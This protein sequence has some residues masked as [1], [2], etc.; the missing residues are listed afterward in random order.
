[1]CSTLVIVVL[2]VIGGKS[3]GH[4]IAIHKGEGNLLVM[5]YMVRGMLGMGE[6]GWGWDM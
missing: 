6:R 5:L 3:P 2:E 4:R 1:M